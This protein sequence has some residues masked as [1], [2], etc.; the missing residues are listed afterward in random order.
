MEDPPS[1]DAPIPDTEVEA[2]AEAPIEAPIEAAMVDAPIPDTPIADT[3]I[4]DVCSDAA[5]PDTPIAD[6]CTDA[7]IPKDANECAVIPL[8]DAGVGEPACASDGAR[9]AVGDNE[10]T[11]PR[12]TA[13]A[14]TAGPPAELPAPPAPPVSPTAPAAPSAGPPAVPARAR[15]VCCAAPHGCCAFGATL[16]VNA[17]VDRIP[18]E[19][20]YGYAT[21]G[22]ESDE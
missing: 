7:A 8:G 16:Y 5:I 17:I 15:C 12:C 21:G 1:P 2:C 9:G 3:P 20:G 13:A 11:P 18:G 10:V 14:L 6:V 22:P 4:A 19:R